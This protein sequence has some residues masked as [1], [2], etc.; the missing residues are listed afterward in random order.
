MY[1]QFNRKKLK[2]SEQDMV[3]RKRASLQNV[4]QVGWKFFIRKNPLRC[5]SFS[6]GSYKLQYGH[7]IVQFSK[8]RQTKQN[9]TKQNKTHGHST[10]IIVS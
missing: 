6:R 3:H 9:K 4:F 8:T 10:Y 5:I 1:N 7:F 2:M